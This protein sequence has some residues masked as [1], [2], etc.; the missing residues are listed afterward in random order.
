MGVTTVLATLVFL[1]GAV[2]V[3]FNPFCPEWVYIVA[4]VSAVIAFLAGMLLFCD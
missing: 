2:A 3:S 1:V 4:D